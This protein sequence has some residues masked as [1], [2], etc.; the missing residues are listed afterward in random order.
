MISAHQILRVVGGYRQVTLDQLTGADRTRHIA[1][2]R[3]EA[4]WLL[5]RCTGLSCPRIGQIIG[6]RDHTTIMA[7]VRAVENRMRD[8]AAYRD[9]VQRMVASVKCVDAAPVPQQPDP[10][11]ALATRI[12]QVPGSQMDGD[13][14]RLATGILTLASVIRD[15]VLGDRDARTAATAILSGLEGA[16]HA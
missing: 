3:Q 5:R 1:W 11:L 14:G 8:D 15:P 12:I 4:Y 2:A 13:A 10:I 6:D 9:E 16:A 7:G